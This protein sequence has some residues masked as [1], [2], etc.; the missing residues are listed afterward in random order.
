MS[1]EKKYEEV[2]AQFGFDPKKLIGR[3]ICGYE[4][5]YY[6]AHGK[7]GVVFHAKK[8]AGFEAAVKI[9]PDNKLLPGWMLS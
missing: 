6:V 3:E 7:M 5:D 2:K 1:L 4:I 9:M 8:N